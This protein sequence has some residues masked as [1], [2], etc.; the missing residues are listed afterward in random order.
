MVTNQGLLI[1]YNL[2]DSYSNH[3]HLY[4]SGANELSCNSHGQY[5]RFYYRV[6]Y[7]GDNLD[8]FS[9]LPRHVSSNLVTSSPQ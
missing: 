8:D 6:H 4:Y 2:H 5:H 3:Y 7:S 9:R 1:G